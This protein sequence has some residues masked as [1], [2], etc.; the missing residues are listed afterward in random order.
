M[1]DSSEVFKGLIGVAGSSA[2]VAAINGFFGYKT[3]AMKGKRDNP[4]GAE[5]RKPLEPEEVRLA[6]GP[7]A[8]AHDV[9]LLAN[10]ASQV[11]AAV[12]KLCLLAEFWICIQ[13]GEPDSHEFKEWSLALKAFFETKEMAETLAAFK[14]AQAARAKAAL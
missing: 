13:K 11:A 3:E 10:A 8:G 12:M 1:L 14:A 5:R 7:L 2:L 9:E 4:P 6:N